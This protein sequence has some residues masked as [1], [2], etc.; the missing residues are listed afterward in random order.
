[1]ERS[2]IYNSLFYFIFEGLAKGGNVLIFLISSLILP[3]EKYL[4]LLTLFSLEGLA[5]V[6]SPFYYTDVLFKLRDK[7]SF[8]E[9][10][11]NLS[12]F[13]LFYALFLIV[14]FT[15]FSSHIFSFYDFHNYL[16]LYSLIGVTIFR[17]LF[18]Q[19]SVNYQINESHKQA[20]KLKVIPFFVSFVGG[21]IGFFFATD[22]IIGFFVGRLV[23]FFLL[24]LLSKVFFLSNPMTKISFTF[25]YDFFKRSSVL[26]LSGLGGWFLSYGMLNILKQFYD[27]EINHEIGLILNLWSLLLLLANGINGTYYPNFRKKYNLDSALGEKVFMNALYLYL[28]IFVFCV[29]SAFLIYHVF[30]NNFLAG[31]SIYFNVLPYVF[32]IFFAQIFQYLSIPYFIVKDRFTKLSSI[33]VITAAI[34]IFLIYSHHWYESFVQISIIHIII[35]CYYVRSLPIYVFRKSN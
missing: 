3:S 19:K 28:I 35:F 27:T 24:F 9:V 17:L 10:E 7:Y 4:Q 33:G 2:R 29:V 14:V 22:R 25:F 32:L 23:G 16:L 26:I 15:S 5:V 12:T 31:F 8:N 34:S 13:I 21:C 1:M 20:I 6:L 30:G 18:Q 11:S